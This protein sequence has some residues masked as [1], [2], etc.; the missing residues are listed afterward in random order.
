MLL[1]LFTGF[2][3]ALATIVAA[4]LIAVVGS[5][6]ATG[7]VAP[8]P[9][10]PMPD[11]GY[12][13]FDRSTNFAELDFPASQYQQLTGI[14][15][16]LLVAGSHRQLEYTVDG[17]ALSLVRLYS[18]YRERFDRAGFEIVFSGI[19]DELGEG[20]GLSFLTHHDGLLTRGAPSTVADSNAYILARSPDERTVIAVS[21]FSRQNARRLMVNA[22]ET[23][24]EPDEVEEQLELHLFP[25]QTCVQPG[26]HVVF[27]AVQDPLTGDQPVAVHWDTSAGLVD[28]DGRFTAPNRRGEV[29]LT[30][31]SIDDPA[32]SASW[33][34]DIDDCRISW[35]AT[36]TGADAPVPSA[37]GNRGQVELRQRFA[38]AAYH[39]ALTFPGNDTPE[40]PYLTIRLAPSRGV[41]P[42]PPRDATPEQLLAWMRAAAEGGGEG[43]IPEFT[44]TIP[45]AT[46]GQTGAFTETFVEMG[47]YDSRADRG[48]AAVIN[49][50]MF[51]GYLRTA[52]VTLVEHSSRRLRGQ[53]QARLLPNETA[54]PRRSEPV[55]GGTG[56]WDAVGE[57]SGIRSWPDE[58]ITVTGSFDFRFGD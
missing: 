16:T 32:L 40:G 53:F 30:A 13:T 23:V 26:E 37:S 28:H 5:Q 24:E 49:G 56:I 17:L 41:N 36:L 18:E 57:G 38:S 52:R 11:G 42:E 7:S 15:D 46:P 19:G 21:F 45:G 39:Q 25:A 10:V 8:H 55:V 33:T 34:L 51:N 27:Q 43:T 12:V 29:T 58:E 2:R 44:I 22:V 9:M 3:T 50:S 6:S 48:D 14:S 20:H 31:R 47:V 1:V 35:Q 54:M 4:A